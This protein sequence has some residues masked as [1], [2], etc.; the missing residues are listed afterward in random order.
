MD[1]GTSIRMNKI[2]LLLFLMIFF[3]GAC[4]SPASEPMLHVSVTGNDEN[5]DGSLL[6]PWRTIQRCAEAAQPGDVC[7]IH[8]GTYRETVRPARSGEPGKPI[9]FVAYNDETVTISGADVV[10]G[11]ARV[12]DNIYAAQVDWTLGRGKDQVFANGAALV[13]A[14]YPNQAEN[15]WA[16]PVDGL[17]PLWLPR[18]SFAS[19]ARHTDDEDRY[20]FTSQDLTQPADFWKGGMYVGWHYWGWSAE[21]G[22]I[23]SSAPGGFL[24]A[25]DSVSKRW[26]CTYRACYAPW[27]PDN[28]RGVIVGAPNALDSA[29]EWILT[30]GTLK[31]WFPNNSDPNSL[32]VEVKRRQLAFDLR[33]RSYIEISGLNIFAA[34]VT[35]AQ[36]AHN[37]IDHCQFEYVSH[38]TLIAD[39]REGWVDEKD[40]M[41]DSSVPAQGLVGIYIGGEENV[42]QN[43]VIRYSAGAGLILQGNRHLVYNNLIE[44]VSYAGTY[45]SA[46]FITYD[47][48][49]DPAPDDQRGG[50]IISFNTLRIAGRSL[51]H[52]NGLGSAPDLSAA[53]RYDALTITHNEIADGM[54]LSNDGGLVYGYGVSLGT[55]ESPSQLAYNVIHDSYNPMGGLVFWDN[56]VWNIHNHHNILWGGEKEYA[57]NPPGDERIWKD[58]HFKKDWSGTQTLTDSD[59]PGGR[60]AFGFG[61][62]PQPAPALP[63]LTPVPAVPNIVLEAESFS[64]QN[65]I[66]EMGAFVGGCDDGDWLAFENIYF[67]SG[68][69]TLKMRA[70]IPVSNAGQTVEA[71]LDSPEGEKIG[72]FITLAPEQSGEYVHQSIALAPVSGTHTLYIVCRGAGRI[73]GFD[74]FRL[75]GGFGATATPA[76]QAVN[77]ALKRPVTVSSL[78]E[79]GSSADWAVDGNLRTRWTSLAFVDPQWI[80]IDLGER[81]QIAR[82][83]LRWE[84]AYAR[85]YRIQVS[86]NPNSGWEDIYVETKGNGEVDDIQ[87]LN[88]AGRYLR[89]YGEQRGSKWGY[90]LWEVEVYDPESAALVK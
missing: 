33:E 31:A 79:T 73:G 47:P 11:W 61:A 45:L 1:S 23:E 88:A 55:S 14:R 53:T 43:S 30:D 57:Y 69:A 8:A 60:F 74:W 72:E 38:F 25:P 28:G 34:S 6:K 4:A 36:S 10:T 77:L 81:R 78:D 75:E 52:I 62:A 86:D 16:Y 56:G 2:P 39:G 19:N 15:L 40:G 85:G 71:R 65:G 20:R 5:G 17:S 46:L 37:V 26:F 87:G 32:T 83:I 67:A 41:F 63:T 9:R 42:I 3:L 24:L 84:A 50:H 48:I 89:I 12:D 90:S 82:V 21:T 54:L 7:A 18:M 76:P 29:R 51:V 70:I 80:V 64:A 22:I 66:Q 27:Y 13:E 44:Q 59:F 58:N 68:Y 49:L 35:M